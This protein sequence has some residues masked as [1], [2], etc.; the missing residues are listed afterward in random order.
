MIVTIRGVDLRVDEAL[1]R[2]LAHASYHVGQIV[3]L[4]KAIRGPAWKWLSIPPGGTEAYNRNP[5]H[6]HAETHTSNLRGSVTGKGEP[7]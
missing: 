4:A 1:H 2:S 5:G 7:G 3:Y 6:E